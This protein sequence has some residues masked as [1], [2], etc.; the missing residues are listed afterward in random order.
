MGNSLQSCALIVVSAVFLVG[1]PA[2]AADQDSNSSKQIGSATNG[3]GAGKV[4]AK[5]LN[6]QP[7]PPGRRL[8]DAA[9]KDPAYDS[10]S[11]AGKIRHQDIKGQFKINKQFKTDKSTPPL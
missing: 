2:L 5:M 3:A 1:Q 8:N 7:L 6:P 9:P 10:G 4:K 11:G